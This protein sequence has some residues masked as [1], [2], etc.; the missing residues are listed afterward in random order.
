MRRTKML[1]SFAMMTA[2][3]VSLF[4]MPA[5][6]EGQ[7]CKIPPAKD[8]VCCGDSVFIWEFMQPQPDGQ[9]QKESFKYAKKFDK[10]DKLFKEKLL[11][12]L[13]LNDKQ[14][15][16]F[17]N[18]KQTNEKTMQELKKEFREKLK[19]VNDEFLQ[20]KY[21][22]KEINSLNKDLQKIS[23]KILENYITE[24]KELRKILTYE[25]YNKLFKHKT[26]YDILAEKLNL[27][28]EQQEKLTKLMETKKE[29]VLQLKEK[30]EQKRK[31]LEEEFNKDNI[32]KD[33]ISSITKEI[34]EISNDLFKVN[35]DTKIEMKSVL[36]QEQYNK[37]NE[38]K[39]HK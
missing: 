20:E 18:L 12:K 39:A 25:Q 27:T 5:K 15:E 1:L 8:I 28:A 30:M 24:K 9:C 22:A 21:A 10:K 31:D 34:S 33:M 6:Q 14:K 3:S 2:F 32:D 13:N 17:K 38:I 23:S 35:I 36:S 19:A 11:E 7:D 29:T 4:A 26:K 16:D 37:L